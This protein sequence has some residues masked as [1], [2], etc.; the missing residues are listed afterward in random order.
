MGDKPTVLI[1]GSNGFLGGRI[2]KYLLSTKR[3]VFRIY[4]H[5]VT[6]AWAAEQYNMAGVDSVIHL[7]SIYDSNPIDAKHS[8]EVNTIGTVNILN[9]AIRSGVKRFIYFSSVH[10]Y[11]SPLRG[12][13][14][15]KTLPRPVSPYAISHKSAEDF[16][17]AAHDQNK[18]TGI[19]LRLSNS[20]GCPA[21]KS[22]NAWLPIVNNMCKQASEKGQIHLQPTA[23]QERDFIAVTDVCRAVEHMLFLPAERCLDGLFNLGGN[24][25]MQIASIAAIV[26]IRCVVHG[27]KC[28]VVTEEAYPQAYCEYRFR[29]NSEKLGYTGFELTRNVVDEID[30]IVKFCMEKRGVLTKQ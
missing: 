26:A 14:S 30:E 17:L 15:E 28:D 24:W 5:D 2:I 25:N 18:I 4:P 9:A 6:D 7:A 13:I 19:V 11:G 3:V 16:V 27:I 10:V 23:V 22:D 1:T 21:H 12:T 8:V 20:F 29:Y